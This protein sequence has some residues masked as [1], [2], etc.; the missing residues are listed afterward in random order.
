MKELTIEQAEKRNILVLVGRGKTALTRFTMS[1]KVY[2]DR[3]SDVIKNSDKIK[4][5]KDNIC[6]HLQSEDEY[7]LLPAGI[8]RR[9]IV[10]KIDF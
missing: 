9:S 10:F 6:I 4:C 5:S 2:H 3:I 8:K 1:T 7:K